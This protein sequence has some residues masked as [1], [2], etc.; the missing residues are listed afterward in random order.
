MDDSEGSAAGGSE[1]EF[2][3]EEQSN[4]SDAMSEG[5]DAQ[6]DQM[7]IEPPEER[8]A[9]YVI[10]NRAEL[11]DR[12]LRC[13][14]DVVELLE[15]TREEGFVLL[16]EHGWDLAR[17][18]EAW[19]QHEAKVR[20]R[21][22]L[23][24]SSSMAPASSS[25][26]T[27]SAPQTCPICMQVRDEP[28]V[29]LDCGH[30]FCPECWTGYLHTQVDDG[31][32]AIQTRC[33]QHKC[34][35]IVPVDF[36]KRFCDEARQTKYDE[37]YL[38]SYVD[39]NQ[40]VKWCTNPSGCKN[41]CE[42]QGGEPGEI[43]CSCC[44]VWCWACGEEAHRPAD[45]KTVNQ[46]NIK[47]SAESENISWIRANTKKCPKCHKPIEKNQGCNHM[48]CSK[49]GGCGHEFCWLCLGDWSTHGTSTGGYYQCNIYDK[50]AKEGKY[51]EEERKMERAKHALDKYM[52]FFERFMD[53]DRGM[54]LTV[55]EEQDIEKKVQTLHDD[56]KFEIIELQFLYDALRQVRVCRRVLK[57]TYVYGYYLEEVG[58]EKNLFEHLQKHLE[59][60]T[61][62]LHEMLEKELDKNFFEKETAFKS[63]EVPQEFRDFRCKVTNFTNVTQKFMQQI[64]TDLGSQGKLT[65]SSSQQAAFSA[66]GRSSC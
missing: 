6:D 46:W 17:L 66:F 2:E 24:P 5:R 27:V 30:G 35:R 62:S 12:Q 13:I 11:V 37:W 28:L 33:P 15:V 44:F 57:W 40:S 14:N 20:D 23:A 32:A 55:K 19:F 10:M 31:K 34:G 41:A 7:V 39:D 60:K 16:R 49:A 47:N 21:C 4:N 42:Y 52:F 63:E 26:A 18:Q 56:H 51:I 64:M 36:F 65:G 48:A 58:P 3:Y 8:K 61:D 59:E 9:P 53:H 22:G 54:R 43:R 45:C 25:T 38:F 29:A 1:S 50:Q